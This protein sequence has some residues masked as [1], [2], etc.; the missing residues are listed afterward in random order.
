MPDYPRGGEQLTA[1]ERAW[2]Q[3]P[4]A[5]VSLKAYLTHAQTL[6]WFAGL[7]ALIRARRAHGLAVVVIPSATALAVLADGAAEAGVLLGAQDCSRE[8]AG[9]FTGELPV[10]LLREVGA[11]VIEVGHA[12]RRRHFGETDEIVAAKTRAVA[13]AGLVPMVCAGESHISE[14]GRHATEHAA[15][16]V[17]RQVGSALHQVDRSIAA[18]ICYEPVWAIGADEPASAGHIIGVARAVK[19]WLATNHPA[20]RFIYGGTAGPGLYPA[21]AGAVDGLGLGRRV[22]DVR[23]LAE[24]FDEMR[25]AEAPRPPR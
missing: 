1:Q 24:V 19:R 9:A 10:T 22:H 7:R 4:I 20:A 18:I 25:S 23:H 5:L 12:E 21:V 3:R 14:S 13:E 15:T 6:E 2:I 17:I 11:T 16:E 8:P